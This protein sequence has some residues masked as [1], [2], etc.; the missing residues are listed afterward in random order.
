MR[1]WSLF[2]SS[3]KLSASPRSSLP[4]WWCQPFFNNLLIAKIMNSRVQRV[5]NLPSSSKMEC[6]FVFSLLLRLVR[7]YSRSRS[8]RIRP[9]TASVNGLRR[10]RWIHR[11][12]VCFLEEGRRSWR[13]RR[14]RPWGVGFHFP[15]GGAEVRAP[16]APLERSCSRDAFTAPRKTQ[17]HLLN[18]LKILQIH[19]PA[20]V[21]SYFKLLYYILYY[22]I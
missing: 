17:H 18:N 8:P 21:W 19:P 15:P 6:C 16:A 22:L 14:R 7:S 9:K 5:P 20:S 13:R 3:R 10:V 12:K 4:R 2:G 1:G 11:I